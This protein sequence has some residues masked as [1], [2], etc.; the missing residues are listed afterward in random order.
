MPDTVIDENQDLILKELY[1]V[2]ITVGGYSV[3]IM[4]T[5]G[6]GVIISAFVLDEE[7]G[8]DLGRL[9]L[10]PYES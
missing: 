7:T 5:K 9:E 4:H 1:A 3:R 6:G 2:W 10:G 8:Q